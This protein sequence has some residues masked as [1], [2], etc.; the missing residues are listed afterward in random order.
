M[1]RSKVVRSSSAN[2]RQVRVAARPGQHRHQL[3]A[4]PAGTGRAAA[5]ASSTGSRARRCGFW[6][7]MPTGQLS[8]WQARMPRQPIAWIAELATATASAPEGQR[9]G[10]VRRVAQPAG[11]HQGD[12]AAPA[13]VEVAPGPGQRRDGGHRDVVAE[14]QR[15]R[16]GAAAAA[17]EDHVVDAD[18]E[19]GVE[20][21]LDVLG[22]QLEADRDAARS[23]A[24]LVGEAPEVVDRV[25]VG[26]AGRRDR[27]R[28]LGQAAHLGD[29]ADH[30]VAGQVAAGAGLGA[31]AALEVEGLHLGQARPSDQ[32]N[33]A[34][35]SS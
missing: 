28:A 34:E 1:S 33:R 15:R 10:E 35:A 31:L 20:V 2:S 24:H 16:A 8:V 9:L 25:P 29:A 27:R 21:V 11:D 22:R 17:V 26:E 7:A 12:V 23:L 19:R 5:A 4:S 32:P 3:D 6:V 18:V 13:P 30:L 14:E